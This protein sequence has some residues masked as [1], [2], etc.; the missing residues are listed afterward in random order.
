MLTISR[1]PDLG[2][3]ED[4][5]QV[6]KNRFE[7]RSCPYQ[8]VLNKRFYERKNMK[9]KEVEDVMGGAGT[10]DN[11]DRTTGTLWSLFVVT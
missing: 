2:L 11:V 4:M 1:I 10:W 9:R 3:S 8:F 7:C 6:G 5:D